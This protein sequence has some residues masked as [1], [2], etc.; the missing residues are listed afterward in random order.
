MKIINTNANILLAQASHKFCAGFI[1]GPLRIIGAIAQIALNAIAL[2]F[3]TIP[4][5][6]G[7]FNKDNTFHA[8]NLLIDA[9]MGFLHIG[10]GLLEFLPGSSFCMDMVADGRMITLISDHPFRGFIDD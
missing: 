10:R 4:S 3:S 9:R 8:K 1:T 7:C 6:L 2:I 5:R